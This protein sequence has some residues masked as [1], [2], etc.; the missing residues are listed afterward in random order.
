MGIVQEQPEASR[1]SKSIG[2]M[3]VPVGLLVVPLD[4]GLVPH[5]VAGCSSRVAGC[6][7][8]QAFHLAPLHF[9]AIKVVC[10]SPYG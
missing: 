1:T 7:Q 6:S 4:G 2:L 10:C 5:R 9:F 8:E 3:N